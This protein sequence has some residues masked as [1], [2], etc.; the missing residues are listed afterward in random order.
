M[1]TSI[2]A[3]IFGTF[4]CAGSS[5]AQ[6]QTPSNP[7]PDNTAPFAEQAERLAAVRSGD[8]AAIKR[9]TAD[10]NAAFAKWRHDH[11]AVA[12]KAGATPDNTAPFTEQAERLA[13]VRSGNKAAIKQSTADENAA[14]AKW[15]H[16]H[17][18]A[19]AVTPQIKAAHEAKLREIA[20]RRHQHTQ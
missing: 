9:T 20:R 15:R 19:A 4:L 5:I 8:K 16:D 10:E 7:Q 18:A 17:P 6:S 12:I 13:A 1:K 11:P 14:F 2:P 3:M